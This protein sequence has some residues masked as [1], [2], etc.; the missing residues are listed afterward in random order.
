MPLEGDDAAAGA[1]ALLSVRSH[2]LHNPGLSATLRGRLVRH[3]FQLIE[4]P[5]QH[6]LAGTASGLPARPRSSPPV[7]TSYRGSASAYLP[8]A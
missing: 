6:L 2:L 4:M 3:G 8:S 5:L 7:S 1:T